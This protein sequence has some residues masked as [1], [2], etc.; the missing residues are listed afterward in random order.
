M[1]LAEI[2]TLIGALAA[3]AAVLALAWIATRCLAMRLPAARFSAAGA[4]RLRLVE[5][6]PLGRLPLGREEYLAV[7]RAGET[8]LLL[9]VSAGQITLL[10]ELSADEAAQWTAEPAGAQP[11]PFREALRQVLQKNQKQEGTKP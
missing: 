9:G 4:G 8:V 7:V 1:P 6:L 10:K 11:M 2:G 3:V 5:R